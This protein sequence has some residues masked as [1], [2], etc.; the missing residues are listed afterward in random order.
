MQ[1]ANINRVSQMRRETT[2]LMY[3]RRTTVPA[4][5]IVPNALSMYIDCFSITRFP[6]TA[7][8]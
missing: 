4:A 5:G 1:L 8:Q 3:G 7:A 6:F 2:A